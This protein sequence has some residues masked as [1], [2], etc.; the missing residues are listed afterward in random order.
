MVYLAG[1]DGLFGGQRWFI[2]RAKMVYL[3]GKD[4]LFGREKINIATQK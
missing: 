2:W 3:A 4:G 1:K